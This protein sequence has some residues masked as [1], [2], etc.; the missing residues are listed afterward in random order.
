MHKNSTLYMYT[1]MY[2][3]YAHAMEHY[4]YTDYTY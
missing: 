3:T 1:L 4:N 2:P